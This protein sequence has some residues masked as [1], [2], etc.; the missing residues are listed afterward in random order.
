MEGPVLSDRE[1][2]AV[3]APLT[4]A[5][6]TPD[7]FPPEYTARGEQGAVV[8]PP[9]AP[10]SDLSSAVSRAASQMSTRAGLPSDQTSDARSSSPGGA[11]ASKRRGPDLARPRERDQ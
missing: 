1:R 2:E 8:P 7:L 4:P 3:M 10:P 5:A 6:P 11:R 9:D